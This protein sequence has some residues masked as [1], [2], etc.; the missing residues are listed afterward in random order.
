MNTWLSFP[1][2]SS[3]P[4]LDDLLIGT[5]DDAYLILPKFK[6]T[7]YDGDVAVDFNN[8]AGTTILFVKCVAKNSATSLKLYY[9]NV[10]I[11]NVYN[12]TQISDYPIYGIGS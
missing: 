5:E 12:I 3:I 1:I 11:S 4:N 6:L 8:T 2:Y 7:V 10:E 9:N